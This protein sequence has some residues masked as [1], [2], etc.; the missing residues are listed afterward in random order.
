MISRNRKAFIAFLPIALLTLFFAFTGCDEDDEP[1]SP[2]TESGTILI[3]EIMA[4]NES[5]FADSSGEF[6]DWIELYNPSDNSVDIGGFSISDDVEEPQKWVFSTAVPEMTT[7]PAKGYLIIWFDGDP[8]QGP[9]HLDFKLDDQGENVCLYSADGEAVDIVYFGPQI[10]DI[11]FGCLPDGSTMKVFLDP[12]TP[13]ATN[14]TEAYNH[15][16][17]I[18]DVE[19]SPVMPLANESVTVTASVTDEFG[20]SEV[21]LYYSLNAIDFE[22]VVMNYVS[23]AEYEAVIPGQAVSSTVSF[24]ISAEDTD[25]ETSTDPTFAPSSCYSYTV[26]E[27]PG[28]S[29]LFINEILASN[30][31]TNVDEYGEADDWIEIYN[32]GTEAV[33]IGG[34][35]ITDDLSTPQ[36]YQIPMGHAAAT[37]IAPGGYL[38]LWAD[39]DLDQGPLHINFKL[40]ADGESVGLY[41]PEDEGGSLVDAINFG[42]QTVDVSFG[43]NSD[44]SSEWRTFQ[45]PTPMSSNR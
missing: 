37:T 41:L 19:H 38:L 26:I 2:I 8:E 18:S 4:K 29:T 25:G 43:R 36:F 33:D 32:A 12:P 39:K 28:G 21:T 13:G 44:G 11:S 16:P 1:T 45:T 27:I 15:A 20:V 24:Y 5:A 10:A 30:E 6:D 22:S 40:S 42:E 17:S 35:Y 9:L 34:M 14:T 7:I 3:N 31:T 23:T